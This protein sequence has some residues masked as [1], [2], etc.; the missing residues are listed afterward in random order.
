LL[1]HLPLS[2]Y[3]WRRSERK[4]EKEK[5]IY[6]AVPPLVFV[7]MGVDVVVRLAEHWLAVAVARV[8]DVVLRKDEFAAEDRSIDLP[9]VS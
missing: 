8:V 4:S 2:H 1:N 6:P 7:V 9:G 3:G 5:E